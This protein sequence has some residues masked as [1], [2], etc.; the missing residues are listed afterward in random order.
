MFFI[1]ILTHAKPTIIFNIPIED[2]VAAI[3][4]S[5]FGAQ[6]KVLLEVPDARPINSAASLFV[7]D[8]HYPKQNC[9]HPRH[10]KLDVFWKTDGLPEVADDGRLV[11]PNFTSVPGLKSTNPWLCASTWIGI[12]AITQIEF[13]EFANKPPVDRFVWNVTTSWIFL[14]PAAGK[15]RQ[16]DWIAK[17]R[18]LS[19]HAPKPIV[20]LGSIQAGVG[21]VLAADCY[22]SY[23]S[24]HDPDYSLDDPLL[25][26]ILDPP[27][28]VPQSVVSRLFDAVEAGFALVPDITSLYGRICQ[29]ALSNY[30]G[31][32]V[33]WLETIIPLKDLGDLAKLFKTIPRTFKDLAGLFLGM[34]YGVL[35]MPDD[36]ET[37]FG[38]LFRVFTD[39]VYP[40]QRLKLAAKE[41][42]ADSGATVLINCTAIT[43]VVDST[44]VLH[45][46]LGITD[47]MTEI[48]NCIPFSFVVDWFTGIGG[49][50]ASRELDF[51]WRGLKIRELCV[52]YTAFV[53]AETLSSFV[54]SDLELSGSIMIYSREYLTEVPET[55]VDPVDIVGNLRRH[56]A[57]G[58]ALTVQCLT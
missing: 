58:L 39:P 36:A 26:E 47:M 29:Q 1:R 54:S 41:T 53:D 12:S 27:S 55:F 37:V 44:L 57:E 32:Q 10:S 20:S 38:T 40:G 31:P 11:N 17:S 51:L 30:F 45:G 3:A 35:P 28:G 21:P 14:D 9:Y 8:T 5:S 43:D 34:K 15:I 6:D 13:Q 4:A 52:G 24:W 42:Y 33:S 23:T 2:G 16:F 19:N 18:T 56:W 25:D 7:D 46:R 48:W 22:W 49:Q 50:I